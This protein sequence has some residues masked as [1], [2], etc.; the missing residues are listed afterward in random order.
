MNGT[1][2]TE[3]QFLKRLTEIIEANLNDEQF[4]VNELARELGMSRATLHRKVKSVIKKSVSE[5]IRETRL[6]RGYE[7]LTNKAG[8]VSEIAY[9]VGFGS[10]TYFTKC[11]HDYYGFSPGE[12]I[13]RINSE[14]D[15][16]RKDDNNLQI[17]KKRKFIIFAIAVVL[18]TASAVITT[19]IIKSLS[20]RHEPSEKTILI[21]P[22]TDNSQHNDS[23]FIVNGL[24]AEIELKLQNIND[25]KIKSNINTENDQNSDLNVIESAKRHKINYILGGSA[26][27]VQNRLKLILRLTE[28]KTGVLIWTK[29]F[30]REITDIFELE[31][32]ISLNIAEA[33]KAEITPE[34][35]EIIKI[36]S[37]KNGEAYTY[38]LRGIDYLRLDNSLI[39]VK[40]PDESN[41]IR[42]KAK[43][44][45]EHAI[46]LDS[47]FADPYIQL[48]NIYIHQ[49]ALFTHD[50]KL[51]DAY[52]DSGLVMI[53]K[54]LLLTENVTGKVNERSLWPNSLKAYYYLKKGK[55]LEAREYFNK[56]DNFQDKKELNYNIYHN[57]AIRFG[58]M[59]DYYENLK[60]ILLYLETKPAESGTPSYIIAGLRE[61]LKN[62]G[63]PELAEKYA[64]EEL[65]LN[66]DSVAYLCNLGEIKKSELSSEA[67]LNL[68]LKA[69]E[70]DS[71]NFW[72][73]FLL[74]ENFALRNNYKTALY[75]L[76]KYDKAKKKSE[77]YAPF[78]HVAG[79]VWLQNGNKIKAEKILRETEIYW[80]NQ[81]ELKT[82][83][84]QI[85]YP[86]I[87]LASIYSTLNEKA[88]ALEFLATLEKKQTIPLSWLLQLKYY[89]M[90][91]NIRE[92]QKFKDL[93]NK[94]ELKYLKDH[95]RIKKLII[96]HGLK[97]S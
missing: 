21:I 8:T 48:G 16:N 92:E 22:L 24:I 3:A 27:I 93:L 40:N 12:T 9:M 68:L 49:L 53:E 75:Y 14:H 96:S 26:Q 45:F 59:E 4:G 39:A 83:D 1:N 82:L 89:P 70:I 29:A 51:A 73:S 78:N 35:M 18:V 19:I 37:T 5:Y 71:L 33:L 62:T 66:N 60:N 88:K 20:K 90:F 30:Q 87:A 47:T 97:A 63:F 54:A 61:V 84:A 56:V 79:F 41:A 28:T 44:Q 81:I 38:Y 86:H 15:I 91:D 31:E 80:K 7:L 57:R 46:A 36:M 6:K 85:Y 95:E 55:T 74:M 67:S 42:Q 10:V 13:N 58:Y 94:L 77:E 65:I 25:L 2:H 72:C 50:L 64:N 43:K 11:F 17:G 52:L 69:Y 32:E 23:T 34:E 76:Q